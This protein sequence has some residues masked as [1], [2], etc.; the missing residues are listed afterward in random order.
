MLTEEE[1]PV[2][3]RPAGPIRKMLPPAL[4]LLLV[5]GAI[6]LA[7]RRQAGLSE[8]G[9]KSDS[10]ADLASQRTL[11]WQ[12]AAANSSPEPVTAELALF[13]PIPAFAWQ[14]VVSIKTSKP[15]SPRDDGKVPLQLTLP[16]LGQAFIDY[17]ATINFS[18]K[19]ITNLPEDL[20]KQLQPAKFIESDD[21]ELQALA[22]TLSAPTQLETAK[23]VFAW[24]VQNVAEA[25]FTAAPLG[26]RW[27]LRNRS[28]D[29]TEHTYLA[30]ALLRANGIPAIFLTGFRLT[31]SPTLKSTDYHN[32]ALAKVEDRWI[33][34]DTLLK[35]F[36]Q[37]T[38]R[39]LAFQ[40]E[41]SIDNYTM[42]QKFSSSDPR[43]RLQ[44]S[45]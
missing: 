9:Q 21:P 1:R 37:S 17:E 35:T 42:P 27:A 15:T 40:L 16:P 44:L 26:A 5:S 45:Q 13:Q 4:I 41:E 8:L 33:I 28:G 7:L 11:R 34:I 43:I 25:P 6:L 30:I 24:I 29:C 18:D 3:A 22:A 23:N 2:V 19:Q 12:I 10:S 20:E 38:D 14:R 36:D 31:D 32:W 39:Y